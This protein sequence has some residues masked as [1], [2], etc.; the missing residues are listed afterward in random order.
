MIL[1][2]EQIGALLNQ[3]IQQGYDPQFYGGYFTENN[4]LIEIAGENAN[5]IIYT[6]FFNTET[7]N[8]KTFAN[9]FYEK[10]NEDPNPYAALAYDNIYMLE[11]AIEKCANTNDSVC[12][13]DNLYNVQIDGV[14]GKTYFDKN[15]DTIKQIYLKTVKNSEFV[16]IK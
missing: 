13:K 14:T 16:L 12:I 4:K 8:A 10:Y 2:V 1:G 6:H 15:G 3:S 11:Q 7:Q 5:G 9:K